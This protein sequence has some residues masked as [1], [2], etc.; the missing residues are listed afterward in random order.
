M[1][2]QKKTKPA[3]IIADFKDTNFDHSGIERNFKGGKIEQ[4]P[5]AVF[6][7]YEHAGLVRTPTT[8][9]KKASAAEDKQ[10]SAA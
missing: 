3:F 10:T 8:E 5:E 2:E 1:S 4:I 6:D 7:N 9:D